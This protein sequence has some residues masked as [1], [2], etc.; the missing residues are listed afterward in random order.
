[1]KSTKQQLMNSSLLELAKSFYAPPGYDSLHNFREKDRL[2]KSKL[3]EA[4]G[5]LGPQIDLV[6][7]AYVVQLI[8]SNFEKS[9][10]E[11][12]E[13]DSQGPIL[14]SHQSDE[15]LMSL[16]KWFKTTTSVE[17]YTKFVR[18]SRAAML[19]TWRDLFLKRPQTVL[20][21]SLNQFHPQFRFPQ[22]VFPQEVGGPGDPKYKSL[23]G[24]K[25]L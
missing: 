19:S 21:D 6:L 17:S 10:C 13:S 14:F 22:S 25:S 9:I 11:L 23:F 1:M 3:I 20:L 8:I 16:K 12:V 18:D 2:K 4:V 7:R 15:V 24:I 5:P